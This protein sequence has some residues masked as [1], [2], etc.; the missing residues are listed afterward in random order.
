MWVGGGAKAPS[1]GHVGRRGPSAP[2][3]GP[4]SRRLGGPSAPSKN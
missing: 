4:V 1:K 2:S 3:K